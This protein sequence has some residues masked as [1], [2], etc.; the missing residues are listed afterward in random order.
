MCSILGAQTCPVHPYFE[1]DCMLCTVAISVPASMDTEMSG[2]SVLPPSVY[3]RLDSLAK[4]STYH[5]PSANIQAQVPEMLS[6]TPV[7]TDLRINTITNSWYEPRPMEDDHDFYPERFALSPEERNPLFAGKH[8]F[9]HLALSPIRERHLSPV[10]DE[11][12]LIILGDPVESENEE[13]VRTR[14]VRKA[15]SKPLTRS[16]GPRSEVPV[17]EKKNKGATSQ[18]KATKLR[19]RLRRRNKRACRVPDSD[20]S[21]L[22]PLSEDED[23][24]VTQSS[25]KR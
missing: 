3:P 15:R 17:R 25:A 13:P 10:Q 24:N 16:K 18:E 6:L 9:D 7:R 2:T 23:G 22:S 14:R 19:Y 11:D 12:P 8:S 1:S 21:D 4:P 5:N 20:S